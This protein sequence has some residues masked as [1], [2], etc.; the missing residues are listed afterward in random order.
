MTTYDQGHVAVVLAN[1]HVLQSYADAFGGAYPGV[2][3]DWTVAE[4]DAGYFYEYYVLPEDWLGA[5]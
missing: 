5:D 1:G 3:D 4:S 2:N